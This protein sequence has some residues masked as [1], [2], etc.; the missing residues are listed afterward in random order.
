MS[1]SYSEM[2]NYL[3]ALAVV[4]FL[5]QCSQISDAENGDERPNIIIIMAD[6]MGYADLGCYG[7]EIQTPNLDQ[8][9]YSGIRF[10]NFYNN[11]K[12]SPSRASLLTGMYPHK[13]GLRSSV[14]GV[15]KSRAHGPNQGFLSDSART[16]PEWLKSVGYTTA[17]SGKWHLGENPQHWPKRRGFEHYFGLISG[18]SS[19][20]RI[21]KDQPRVRQMVLEDSLWS[22]PEHGF[23]M[24]DAIT[25][26]AVD[27]LDDHTNDAPYFLYVAYTAPHWPLHAPEALIRPYRG[28]YDQGWDTLRNRRLEGLIQEGILPEQT[29]LSDLPA[30]VMPWR[31][32]TNKKFWTE[33]MEVYAAM[34]HRMDQGVGRILE[35]VKRSGSWDNTLIIFLSDNGGSPENITGRELHDT[36]AVIGSKGSYVAYRET[37]ALVSCA[38]WQRYKL[39]LNEGGIAT[40]MI[41]HWPREIKNTNTIRHY[42]GHIMD[43]LPTL[44]DING[45]RYDTLPQS[46]KKID[47]TSLWP[48]V[49]GDI[50]ERDS[51]LVWEFNGKR[52]IMSGQWKLLADENMPWRLYNLQTDRLENHDVA[53]NNKALIDSLSALYGH[54]ASEVN[55]SP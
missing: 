44:L 26:Y 17:M 29:T 53:N 1:L 30:S 8:L 52:A 48:A 18:A 21:R 3:S 39:W 35:A 32:I 50:T 10:S 11:A 5:T 7:S 45:I 15:N 47:G 38:P 49:K 55:I 42:Q 25:D 43:L 20:Y 12:C 40:P 22:P 9:G 14:V 33:R 37:W 13:A 41:M 6:D 46:L 34:I 28:M 54:W 2:I 23:Y 4:C 27:F 51:P 24:T 19:Y 31:N 36:T 16:I